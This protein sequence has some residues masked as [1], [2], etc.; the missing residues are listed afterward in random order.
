ML[1]TIIA[2]ALLLFPVFILDQVVKDGVRQL[3]VIFAFTLAFAA[4]CSI[5]T[6]ARKQE[7]FGAAAGY[8]AVLVVFLANTMGN[9]GTENGVRT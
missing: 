7:V 1:L 2:T 4:C 3:L 5:F 9:Y 6:N 8:C